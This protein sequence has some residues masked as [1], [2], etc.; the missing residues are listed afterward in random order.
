MLRGLWKLTWLEI[1][2]FLRE[3]LGVVGSVGVPVAIFVLFG[4]LLGSRV[5]QATPGVPRAI[6]VDLP[7]LTSILIIFSFS[8]RSGPLRDMASAPR[9]TPIEFLDA[10]G[11]LYKSA[12]ASSTAVSIAPSRNASAALRIP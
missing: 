8:R 10:L 2:I 5:Q 1:K 11:S 3:P 4:R 6:S 9:A 12:G 7:I